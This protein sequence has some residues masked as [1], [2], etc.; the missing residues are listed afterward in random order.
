MTAMS[1]QS[2]TS[3]V[4]LEFLDIVMPLAYPWWLLSPT[5]FPPGSL[6]GFV[7]KK[8]ESGVARQ[9]I[10]VIR[11]SVECQTSFLKSM[12]WGYWVLRDD[13][14]PDL[15]FHKSIFSSNN[16]KGEKAILDSCRRIA[17]DAL[18]QMLR[19]TM[20][21]KHTKNLALKV[22][23]LFHA[24]LHESPVWSPCVSLY[25]VTDFLATRC[26]VPIQSIIW[27]SFSS[28][29]GLACW[30]LVKRALFISTDLLCLSNM[31]AH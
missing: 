5:S 23:A 21:K 25:Y 13:V 17:I 16:N 10:K 6:E 24:K 27:L 31:H 4:S 3:G 28:I 2:Q 8:L 19:Y 18:T 22:R 11:F 29:I 14:C 30:K 15:T 12:L 1:W 20:Q 7:A 26:P 9:A